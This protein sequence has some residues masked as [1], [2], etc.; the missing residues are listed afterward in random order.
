MV[1][2]FEDVT[3]EIYENVAAN[4]ATSAPEKALGMV[5]M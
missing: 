2:S 1:L 3:S 4:I 5:A